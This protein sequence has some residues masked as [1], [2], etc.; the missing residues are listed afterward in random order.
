VYLNY[1]SVEDFNALQAPDLSGK[2]A[3]MKLGHTSVEEKVQMSLLNINVYSIMDLAQ[4]WL[5]DLFYKT[6]HHH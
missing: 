2:L 4:N 5:P 6:T 1:G 3:L